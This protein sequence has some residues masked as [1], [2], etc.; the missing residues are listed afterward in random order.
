MSRAQ[1]AL[2][3]NQWTYN[4]VDAICD[5]WQYWRITG[6]ADKWPTARIILN[7][8]FPGFRT[9]HRCIVRRDG[10][11]D[12]DMS[13]WV[14]IMWMGHLYMWRDSLDRLL[15]TPATSQLHP[16]MKARFDWSEKHHKVRGCSC[17]DIGLVAAFITVSCMRFLARYLLRVLSED[18]GQTPHAL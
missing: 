15:C 11:C 16:V 2:D 7:E 6:N 14:Q 13:F 10:A 4:P 3:E 8:I 12:W 17:G 9:A 18:N 1:L 5:D